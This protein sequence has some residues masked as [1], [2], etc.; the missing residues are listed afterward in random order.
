GGIWDPISDNFNT[1]DWVFHTMMIIY[2]FFTTILL[3]NVLISLIN[4]AFNAGDE[5][6]L[7]VWAE[8]RLRYVESAES[9]TYHIPGF[10]EAHDWFPK[11]IYYSATVQEV[12]DYRARC[13]KK[14]GQDFIRS[15]AATQRLFGQTSPAKKV[16]EASI[17]NTNNLNE[18]SD[19]CNCNCNHRNGPAFILPQS[20]STTLAQ[21]AS[22]LDNPLMASTDQQQQQAAQDLQDL[23]AQLAE[24]KQMLSLLC[25]E[26]VD[27]KE[28]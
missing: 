21:D 7:L 17:N 25:K 27:K 26:K 20:S 6:W 2:F 23:K 28:E 8:N 5:T 24:M 4:V 3:L 13:F 19:N 16:I 14:D 10:R 9:M 15:D 12:N 22:E 18:N 11:E 1:D